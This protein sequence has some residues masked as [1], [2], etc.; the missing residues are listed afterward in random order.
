MVRRLGAVVH[1]RLEVAIGIVPLRYIIKDIDIDGIDVRAGREGD[2]LVD[3]VD[4]MEEGE[5]IVGKLQT[6]ASAF[7]LD[8]LLGVLLYLSAIVRLGKGL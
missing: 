7:A 6:L 3:V 8:I 2:G 4:F 5:E 1:G